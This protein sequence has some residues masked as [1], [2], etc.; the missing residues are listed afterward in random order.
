M[1]K[2]MKNKK[3]WIAVAVVIIVAWYM[4]GGQAPVEAV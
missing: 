2:L 1:K 3:V 4:F